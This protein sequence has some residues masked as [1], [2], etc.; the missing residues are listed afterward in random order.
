MSL[1]CSLVSTILNDVEGARHLLADLRAQT[2]YPTEFVVVDGGST[3]GSYEYLCNSAGDLPFRLVVIQERGANVS[4][5]RNLAIDAASNDI[6]LTTDFGCRLDRAWVEELL[7]PF[8][9]DPAIEIVTGSWKIRREDIRT[10]A[11]WAEWALAGGKLELVATP[12]CLASTRSIAF[13]RQ[14]WID[15]GRYPE[16][17][18][19]AGDDAIFSLW[20]VSSGRRIDAAPAAV[21]YWHRFPTLRGYRKEARRNFRGAGEAV[22]FLSFGV[23]SGALFAIELLTAFVLVASLLTVPV[24]GS[25]EIP[26]LAAVAFGIVWAK[27]VIKWIRAVGLLAGQGRARHWA[28]VPL[29]DLGNRAQGVIGYWEGFFGGRKRCRPCRRRMAELNIRRW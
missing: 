18:S 6:I 26:A 14:V 19:L 20:M 13:R 27:R 3:D 10:P 21:C 2:V 9:R 22:F 7:K 1:P 8:L 24:H 5:G 29:F 25:W 17:L 23:K 12:T 15:F 28:Y 16:D 4:R 11:Q